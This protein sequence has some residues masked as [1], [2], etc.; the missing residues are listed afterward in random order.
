M[1]PAATAGGDYAVNFGSFSTQAAADRI[2][3]QLR[4]SQLPGF[5]ETATVDGRRVYR[6]RIGPYASRAQAEAARLRAAH[7]RDDVGARVVTLDAAD[8]PAPARSE[9]AKPEPAKPVAAAPGTAQ[10]EPAAPTRPA[11]PEPAKPAA[12]ATGFAVQVGAFSK[13]ADAAA[14]RDKLRAAGFTAFTEA[15]ST[16]KGTLTRV[17]VGPVLARAEADQLKQQVRAKAGIDGIVRPHP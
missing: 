9:P 12:A 5:R 13:A 2:V 6:V 11:S 3:G 16:D 7:V 15:V 1:F 14:L 8:E 17:R 4:G 10:P